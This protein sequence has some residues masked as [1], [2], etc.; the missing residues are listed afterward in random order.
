MDRTLNSNRLFKLFK[1]AFRKIVGWSLIAFSFISFIATFTLLWQRNYGSCIT[2]LMFSL[3]LLVLGWSIQTNL[4]KT[5][6]R[7]NALMKRYFPNCPICKSDKGYQVK[8]FLPSSQYVKCNNCRAEWTS[9]DFI[10]YKDLESMK[11][12][13]P[14][15]D[16]EIYAEFI[17]QS[18]LKLKKTYPVNLWQA[19]MNNE[20]I[21][22]PEK[23]KGIQLGELVASQKNG[24]TLI[25]SSIILTVIGAFSFTFDYSIG[26]FLISGGLALAVAV[27]GFYLFS[28]SKE[29]SYIL[30]WGSF[31]PIFLR[32]ITPL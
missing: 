16:P 18:P 4:E 22:F 6:N 15:E 31:I 29:K 19:M 8:G 23:V 3:F 30:F 1:I 25:L 12:F 14:P 28:L 2:G 24:V 26:C 10:G 7:I 32:L 21:H 9:R 5:R 17:S 20:E 27:V 11:L 13:K